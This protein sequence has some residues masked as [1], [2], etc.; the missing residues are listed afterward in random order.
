MKLQLQRYS[1]N[2]NSTMGL[3]HDVSSGKPAFKAYTL[4]DEH[5]DLKLRGQTRIPAG[6][7]VVQHRREDTPLT[8][9]YRAKY[10]WF[11]YH[12]EICNVPN[13]IGIYIHIGNNDEHTDGCVLVGD[14]A[15]NNMI[16]PGIIGQSTNAFQRL[17]TE[18]SKQLESG[19]I[20]TITIKNE[21]DL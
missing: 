16:Q 19:K 21:S 4:E 12:L 17:Y 3:L 14:T 10:P 5:R 6:T 15:V 2:G 11:K 13:F 8:L 7:Y 9:K 1:D 18:V 20:V